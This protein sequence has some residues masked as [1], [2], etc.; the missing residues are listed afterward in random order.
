[1]RPWMI[2]LSSA[3]V[4]I[5][6]AAAIA[7]PELSLTQRSAIV[8]SLMPL[9]PKLA[10]TALAAYALCAILLTA[11]SLV[12]SSLRLRRHLARTPAHHG[13]AGSDWTAAFEA[14]ALRRLA[15]ALAFAP[16]RPP[17]ADGTVVVQG[18]FRP[19]EARRETARLC[20]IWAARTHFFSA[21]IVLAAAVGLGVAQQYGPLPVSI[22][23]IPT[24][25]AASIVIGLM[26]LAVLTRLAVDV[27]VEPLIEMVARLPAEP[28]EVALLRRAIELL[29]AGRVPAAARDAVAPVA[30]MQIPDRLVGVFEEG[31]RALVDAVERLSATTAVLAATARSS[32]EG[33]ETAVRDSELR[34]Q[35]AA[36]TS[37]IDS[38]GLSR[39]QD[40]VAAL[41]AALE[42]VPAWPTAG[43]SVAGDSAAG[44]GPGPSRREAEPDLARE[45]K[46]LLQEIGTAS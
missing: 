33:L 27:T 5:V 30:A 20:Y 36:E 40:V 16:P 12:G 3:A 7:R 18:R 39:L 28:V 38:A 8:P 13:P 26:L 22:G 11:G 19:E 34:G 4:A 37:I 9:L 44:I 15:P 14:S 25:P 46:T 24:V 35:P 42:R 23:P 10:V 31:H 32:I 41:T 2:V 6:A 43:D 21:L 45:L 17:R 1:M 29:E